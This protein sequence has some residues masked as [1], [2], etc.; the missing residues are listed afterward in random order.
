MTGSVVALVFLA[1]M[2]GDYVVQSHWMACEKTQRWLPA[3]L[4]GVTYTACYLAVTRSVVALLV[5][6]G[7]HV[8]IDRYRLA[9]YVVW[10][11][12]HLAPRSVWRPWRECVVTG[13][14]SVV[15]A[16]LAV[17]LMIVADNTVHLVINFA[18]VAWL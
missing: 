2:A 3:V 10:L 1:H 17:W 14:P 9:R 12:N 15:P 6:G 8:V 13:Y 18:A 11:K 7:T 16:W 4:H 5:I